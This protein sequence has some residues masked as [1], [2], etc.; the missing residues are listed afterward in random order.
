LQAGSY[1]EREAALVDA[2][3]RTAELHN[4]VGLTEPVDPQVRHFYNRPFLVLMAERIVAA[5]LATVDDAALTGL[6]LIGSVDQVADSTDLLEHPPLIAQL[7][8]L[9][10]V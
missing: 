6:P 7:R 3:V 1:P 4:T 10:Q 8:A 2:Y 9:Y 5:C